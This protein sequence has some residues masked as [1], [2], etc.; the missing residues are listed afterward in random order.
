MRPGYVM[1]PQANVESEPSPLRD[2]ERMQRELDLVDLAG[3]LGF[4][5]F[6]VTEHHFGDYNLAPSPL[7][8]L[9]YVAGRFPSASLGTMVIVLPWNDPLRVVEQVVLL[10]YLSRGRLLVGFGKGDARREFTAFGVDLARAR[11]RFEESLAVVVEGLATGVL[12]GDGGQV[13]EVRPRPRGSFENRLYM[14]AGSPPSLDRAA[15][16]GLGLLRIALRS[17]EEVAEQVDRHRV[18]FVAAHGRE[19]PPTVALTYGFVDRD[20]GRA[21]ELGMGFARAY[22]LSAIDHYE[23][24]PDAG[25]ELEA[26][27]EAQLWGTPDQVVEKAAYLAEATRTGHLAYAFRYAGVPYEE[28]IASMRLFAREVAP[29]LRTIPLP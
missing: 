26:F 4:D 20:P 2:A 15:D 5:E 18:R 12:T 8:L 28:A 14:A 3:G 16:S 23:L 10:D 1:F 11:E 21:R 24:G 13:I 22:R 6:W 19:P 29:R 27:A 25:A 17:W 9:S 7:Q